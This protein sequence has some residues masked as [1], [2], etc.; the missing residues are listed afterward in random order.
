[1]NND[2]IISLRGVSY[3]H[4]GKHAPAVQDINLEIRR[5]TLSI[6]IGPSGSGKTT[7]CDILAGVIPHLYGGGL[8]GEI[9]IDG[10]NSVD[11]EVHDIALK[12]G[13]VFQDP[14]VMFSMLE[15]EDEIAFG[16]ENLAVPTEKIP[17]IVERVLDYV[18]LNEVRHNLV[19]E[20]S[21]GQVQRLGLGCI[22][23][24]QTPIIVL[25][26]PTANLDPIATRNVHSLALK[27]KE[28]GVTVILVTKES[29][30]FLAQADSVF[31]LNKGKLEFSGRPQEIID[32]HGAYL[33]EELG[34]WLPEVCELGMGMRS[35]GLLSTIPTPLTVEDALIILKDA[36]FEFS[37]NSHHTPQNDHTDPD[38]QDSERSVL[39]SA[40]DLTFSYPGN[41]P[42]LRGISFKVRRGDLLAV[43]GRNGAGKST[44]AR[45]L[46]G[47]LKPQA[48]ILELFG[49]DATQWRI[50]DLARKIALVFQ[51][52]EHQ[53]LT[54]TVF[55]EIAYSY[56][57]KSG[58]DVDPG[59]LKESV[60]RVLAMLELEDVAGDHPF[61][62]SAGN[63]RR[64][65]VAAM[66]VGSPEVLVVD[67][68]TYG[69]DKAMTR[70][71]MDLILGLRE[72][73]ITIV[74]ITH[75]MRLVEEY[76][77]RVI[78]MNEGLI[79]F[80]GKPG[81]L[82]SYPDIIDQASLSVTSLQVL[83]NELRQGGKLV[84]PVRSVDELLNIIRVPHRG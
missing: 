61:S 76:A 39:I 50:P 31:V 60:N 79:T 18:Q 78:V 29:D 80:D 72:M 16:P 25:D 84:P 6:I 24:M 41:R 9:I 69:Q 5:G 28:E 68:P 37:T 42:A 3:Y 66:L 35:R 56:L 81:D 73:G 2:I 65:G 58:G 67:E 64:L 13:K 22:L 57:S 11:H 20:L 43:V 1:M 46:V 77:D 44:L 75:S 7:L 38:R 36:S 4:P 52:P 21:G 10:L 53:F 59:E 30:E 62:L 40:R 17:E 27:L 33:A 19:W 82:F 15:V 49:Q 23:A 71:L 8:T 34:V 12:V 51:N 48:G 47:L 14:E 83:L 63:K 55:D 74:M 54:D 26:E 45:L 70:S 32:E